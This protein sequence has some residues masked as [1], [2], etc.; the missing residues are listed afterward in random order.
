MGLSD[1]D[2]RHAREEEP[3]VTIIDAGREV[4]VPARLEGERV[5][6]SPEALRDA[7]GWEVHDGTLCN[8]AMCVPLPEG[9]P[10][11]AGGPL[12]LTEIA[13]VLD[14]PLALDPAEAAAF[15]GAAAG[16]RAAALA[17]LQAP[18]FTLPDLAGRPH[19][20]AEHR[21]KKVLL[22]AWASW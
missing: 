7:L 20:L 8:D 1:R 13:A 18:D 12:D 17:S 11:A 21:G 3:M 15:L 14:R 5:L 22:V 6:L 19:T 9:S 4:E 10:L 2:E 16:E